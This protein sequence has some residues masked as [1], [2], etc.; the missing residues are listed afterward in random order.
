MSS[1]RERLLGDYQSPSV[2]DVTSYNTYNN[3]FVAVK[4]MPR[5][6]GPKLTNCCFVLSVW[7]LLMMLIMGLLFRVE[8]V[9][10]LEDL[11]RATMNETTSE[12]YQTTSNSCFV[13]AGLYGAVLVL[14]SY[15]KYSI[16]RGLS[17]R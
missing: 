8:S 6:C 14:C 17:R 3:S 15:Q 9:A 12:L 1:S 16:S 4:R 13:V 5:L 7:G 10:L 2:V 11:P